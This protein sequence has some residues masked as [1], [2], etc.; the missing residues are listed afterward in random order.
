MRIDH[1][2]IART[3]MIATA[4]GCT[5]LAFA[6][7]ASA[8]KILLEQ[9]IGRDNCNPG[10]C[11]GGAV[12]VT[13]ST[14]QRSVLLAAFT[15]DRYTCVALRWNLD[16]ENGPGDTTV[17]AGQEVPLLHIPKD[18]GKH[19]LAVEA[20]SLGGCEQGGR[21]DGWGGTLSVKE[22]PAPDQQQAPQ[23]QGPALATVEGED[24]NVY[25]GINYPEGAANFLGI[26]AVGKQIQ[27]VGGEAPGGVCIKDVWCHV[28]GADVPTGQGWI[29]GHLKLPYK[30]S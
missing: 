7:P 9:H 1:R 12:V 5:A 13:F 11:P 17:A 6:I 2:T 19:T 15:A 20:S 24:V 27:V 4:T 25:D 14:P 23:P 29:W 10:G 30:A 28:R 3:A 21:Q 18:A 8:E 16:G 22:F 26:L